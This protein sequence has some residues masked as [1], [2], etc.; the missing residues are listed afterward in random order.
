MTA[1]PPALYPAGYR[2]D[3]EAHEILLAIRPEALH[4]VQTFLLK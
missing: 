3:P 4:C 1:S 2:F